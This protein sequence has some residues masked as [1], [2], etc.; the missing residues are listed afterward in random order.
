MN[1]ESETCRQY[2]RVCVCVCV[3]VMNITGEASLPRAESKIPVGQAQSMRIALQH[4]LVFFVIYGQTVYLSMRAQRHPTTPRIEDMD[5]HIS[6]TI[7]THIPPIHRY[8]YTKYTRSRKVRDGEVCVCV[9]AGRDHD[10]PITRFGSIE[11]KSLSL[12]WCFW[13]LTTQK[14]LKSLSKNAWVSLWKKGGADEK[15]TA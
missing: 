10:Y 8:M 4:I 11:G 2:G 15:N 3:C 12:C 7:Q 14:A 5:T 1:A 9:C 13:A 6:Q